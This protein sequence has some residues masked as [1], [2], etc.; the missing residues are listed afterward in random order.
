MTFSIIL[1]NCVVAHQTV[2]GLIMS[3]PNLPHEKMSPQTVRDVRV[4]CLFYIAQEDGNVSSEPLHKEK[5]CVP[6]SQ[7]RQDSTDFRTLCPS[8]K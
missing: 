5:F 3:Y 6:F 2:P 8:L 7:G 1:V 4:W